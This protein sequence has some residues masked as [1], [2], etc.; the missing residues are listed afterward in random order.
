MIFDAAA[1]ANSDNTIFADENCAI[2]ND[3]E[4]VE[5]FAAAGNGAAQGE[6]LRAAGDEPVGHD[7]SDTT[8]SQIQRL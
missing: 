1:G 3:A 4:V 5:G 8:A 6:Q 7:A 2:A